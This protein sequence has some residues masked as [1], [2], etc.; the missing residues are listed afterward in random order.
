MH[1]IRMDHFPSHLERASLAV[2]QPFM[3]GVMLN[4]QVT[5][6]RYVA[7]AVPDLDTERSFVSRTWGLQ[8]VAQ[9]G[10]TAFFA[11][12]GSPEASIFRLRKAAEKRMD[13]LAFAVGSDAAVD[14]RYERLQAARVQMISRPQRLD[15][16]G[17]GYGFRFFDIDG[18]TVEIS[19]GVE[20]RSARPLERGESIPA[21]LSHVVLHTPDIRKSAAFYQEHLGL[22]V[23]DWLGNFM[24]FLRCNNVHHCLAFLPGPVCFNHAAFEMRDLDEMMRGVAR[25]VKEGVMLGW[26][27]GRHTAGNNTFAYF[28][29]PGGNVLEYTAEVQRIDESTWQPTIYEPGPQITDQWGTGAVFGGG[30]QKL[31]HPAPDPGLWVAPPR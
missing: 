16:P 20:P 31:G 18:R 26:G 10:D 9:E 12:E 1:H 21:T 24:C 2:T 15:G 3:R 11:A 29:T 19:S 13:V 28:M 25:L 17:G 5:H 22:R 27:P 6:M 23:S 7:L 14:A 4:D 8:Q 30:P